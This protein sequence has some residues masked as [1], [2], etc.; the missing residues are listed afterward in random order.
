MRPASFHQ[1]GYPELTIRIL[2]ALIGLIWWPTVAGAQTSVAFGRQAGSPGPICVY[3]YSNPPSCLPFMSVNDGG[4]ITTITAPV[5]TTSGIFAALGV[6]P[7]TPALP[8]DVNYFA[9][10]ASVPAPGA[11]TTVRIAGPDGA[12]NTI[13][14]DSFGGTSALKCRRADGTA[15]SPLPI[16]STDTLPL[17]S[18]QAY[19]WN[20]SAYTTNVVA[21]VD[22]A[23][24]ETGNWN[25]SANGT[26]ARF[27]TTLPG[28][29]GPQITN[30]TLYGDGGLYVGNNGQGT[31][32]ANL[33][34]DP[35]AYVV[36]ATG[37][38]TS[39]IMN[40]PGTM[41][42]PNAMILGS[43]TV[44][45]IGSGF[46]TGAIVN[47]NANGTYAFRVNV[48]TGGTASTGTL[49]MPAGANGWKCQAT[50]VT[51]TSAS[52]F[53]TK[54]SGSGTTFVTF[55]NY[56]TSGAASPWAASDQL[57]VICFGD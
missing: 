22:F 57:S 46:G 37:G 18:F 1:V 49:T 16:Q 10:S 40:M 23:T 25:T 13:G 28:T 17:C 12:G 11:S 41:V 42:G 4:L 5:N 31:T 34:N 14:M 38:V 27:R 52:V 51:T 24:A 6:G 47:P 32:P 7:Q 21:S 39:P 48:G 15:A 20:G 45:T 9:N 56:N 29:I 53:V 43:S 8:F 2:L 50:D 33:S 35:G 26:L 54:Q 30:M 19:G 44:P 3:S 55:T 36:S